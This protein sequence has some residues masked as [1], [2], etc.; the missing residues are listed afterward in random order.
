[1]RDRRYLSCKIRRMWRPT[2]GLAKRHKLS[3]SSKELYIIAWD[4]QPDAALLNQS[5]AS[6]FCDDVNCGAFSA[7][8]RITKNES[9]NVIND[10]MRNPRGL[11]SCC[12][13]TA[14]FIKIQ[15]KEPLSK[16]QNE[17]RSIALMPSMRLWGC[18]RND[19]AGRA[20]GASR[21][22]RYPG[23]IISCSD[24]N[25]IR[26]CWPLISCAS[27]FHSHERAN[28]RR[29]INQGW[30]PVN[31][32]PNMKK[33]TLITS[34][35]RSKTCNRSISLFYIRPTDNCMRIHKVLKCTSP[36]W[37]RSEWLKLPAQWKAN[38]ESAFR[39]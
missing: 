19:S 13:R 39:Y 10:I 6:S 32:L 22:H 21:L 26:L 28:E 9:R 16:A 12:A 20:R 11:I 18:A 38:S 35:S 15:R 5:F 33:L 24:S 25:S 17:R 23:G 29:G 4:V 8:D 37:S 31:Q 34:G 14:T 36:P 30:N 1:M 7:D 3:A 27:E 2:K